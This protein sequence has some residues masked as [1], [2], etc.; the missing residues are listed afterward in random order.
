M[1]IITRKMA[2]LYRKS[3]DI[4]NSATIVFVFARGPLEVPFYTLTVQTPEY[5]TVS[6]KFGH[7]SAAPHCPTVFVY[8]YDLQQLPLVML[9]YKI[10]SELDHQSAAPHCPS[11]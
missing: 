9:R 5:K 1:K 7:Q 8:L 4:E 3:I 6:S 11:F 2:I 10:I